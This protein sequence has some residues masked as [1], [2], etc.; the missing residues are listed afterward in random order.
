MF[1]YAL[2]S[3]GLL[4]D[5][6]SGRVVTT[7]DPISLPLPLVQ[8]FSVAQYVQSSLFCFLAG[9]SFDVARLRCGRRWR[10]WAGH[11]G[12]WAERAYFIGCAVRW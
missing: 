11:G 3:T 1:D 2:D 9:R 6:T 8:L 5:S 4:K 12:G 7:G 10:K